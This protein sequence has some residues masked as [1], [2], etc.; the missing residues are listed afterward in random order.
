MAS[1]HINGSLQSNKCHEGNKYDHGGGVADGA[2]TRVRE[3][4]WTCLTLRVH[5]FFG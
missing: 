2:R 3:V 5:G 1:K 4:L